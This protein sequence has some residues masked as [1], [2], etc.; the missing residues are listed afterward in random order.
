MSVLRCL[1]CESNDASRVIACGLPMKFCQRCS[2]LWGEPWATI[3]S[4]LLAPFEGLAKGGFEF[5]EYE[6]SYFA[7]LKEWWQGD[8]DG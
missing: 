5:M 2:T 7:A 6:G 4:L 1:E 3:Y 8:D